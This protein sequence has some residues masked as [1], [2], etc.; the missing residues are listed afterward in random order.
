MTPISQQKYR[1][2]LE[3]KRQADWKE[4]NMSG[5]F[6]EFGTIPTLVF[7]EPEKTEEKKTELPAAQSD[8]PEAAIDDSIFSEEEKKM[9]DDFSRKIDIHNS[10]AI[11]EYGAGAQKKMADF[12]EKALDNVRNKDMGEIG[13]MVAGLVTELENFDVEEEKGIFGFFKKQG[14]RAAML[15]S[16]YDKTQVSVDKICSSLEAH[17]IQ[18]MKDTAM[19]DKMYELNLTYYKELTM[20][21]VAGKKRLKEIREHDLEQLMERAKT[22]GAPEDAQ[23]AKDLDAK[24]NRFEKKIHDLELTRMISMQTAPQIRMVQ[25]SDTLMVEKIQSTLVNTIPLWKNQMVIALGVEHSNQAARAQRQVTDL[26]NELLKKNA[27]K[28]KTA[29]VETARESERGVVDIETLKT[30][31]ASLISTLDEVV[32]IQAEGRTKRRSAEEEMARMENE[33]KNKLLE[34]SK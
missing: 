32:K 13:D 25:D 29:T 31:N 5:E 24:C 11:L 1:S 22:T 14:N 12:S 23:A 27:E 20:Y 16:K 2:I 8:K 19:L 9:V 30:T 10:S 34:M 7:G 3:E 4:K 28:L 15:K 17:Q 18:L 6:D 21:I 33:L 26:T